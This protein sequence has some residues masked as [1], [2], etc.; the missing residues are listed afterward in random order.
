MKVEFPS[1][2]SL[3]WQGQRPSTCSMESTANLANGH[4]NG[5]KASE[6]APRTLANPNAN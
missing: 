1:Q 3:T 4:E 6:A 2:N 5:P